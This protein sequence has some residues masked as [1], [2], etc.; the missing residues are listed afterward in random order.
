M[1]AYLIGM[2]IGENQANK[3]LEAS[4]IDMSKYQVTK[5]DID[6]IKLPD[7]FYRNRIAMD[8]INGQIDKCALTS[9]DAKVLIK[10]LKVYEK[11][12]K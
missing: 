12:K 11:E 2:I 7:S 1:L 5:Q 3:K 8:V 6:E 9:D 10:E 4:K